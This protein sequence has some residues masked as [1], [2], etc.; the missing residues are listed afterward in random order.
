MDQEHSITSRPGVL[1][2]C[3][4][5]VVVHMVVAMTVLPHV[6][7]IFSFITDLS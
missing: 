2:C 3:G 4:N 5:E 7:A 6:V 1:D